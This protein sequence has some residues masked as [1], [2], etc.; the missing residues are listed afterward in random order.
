MKPIE[1]TAS[2]SDGCQTQSEQDAHSVFRLQD[3]IARFKPSAD[4]SEAAVLSNKLDNEFDILN[5]IGKGHFGTVYKAKNVIDGRICAIKQAK[6]QF[7][8][9]KDRELKEREI[10]NWSKLTNATFK[11]L[12]TSNLVRLYEAWEENGYINSSSEF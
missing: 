6:Q 3:G 7:V 11:H 5:N 12:T 2:I 4:D 8:S 9:F 10:Q 1:A